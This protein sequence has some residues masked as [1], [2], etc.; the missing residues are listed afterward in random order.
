[1]II[2]VVKLIM[3]MRLLTQIHLDGCSMELDASGP[4]EKR[5]LADDGKDDDVRGILSRIPR[6]NPRKLIT[7][8]PKQSK[9]VKTGQAKHTKLSLVVPS[10]LGKK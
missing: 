3:L 6:F 2:I 4:S 9:V 1:M 5:P 7:K 10:R 8:A